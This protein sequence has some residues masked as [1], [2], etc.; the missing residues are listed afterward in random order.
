ME[1]RSLG[2]GVPARK[3]TAVIAYALYGLHAG[4]WRF[5]GGDVNRVRDDANDAIGLAVAHFALAAVYLR[6]DKDF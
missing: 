3:T 1:D 4:F 6:L 5:F 2:G